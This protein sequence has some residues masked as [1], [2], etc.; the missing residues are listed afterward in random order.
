MLTPYEVA[1]LLGFGV[2]DDDGEHM[3]CGTPECLSCDPNV[4]TL[5]K[6][7]Y[8]VVPEQLML[9]TGEVEDGDTEAQG[10][11][12]SRAAEEEGREEERREQEG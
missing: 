6:D 4:I 2:Y 1:Q 3:G 11:S 8:R 5:S 10:S 7:D 9:T 12:A